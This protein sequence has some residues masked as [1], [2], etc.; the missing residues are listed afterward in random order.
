MLSAEWV[1][2]HG[3]L[4]TRREIQQILNARHPTF[5][6]RLNQKALISQIGGVSK[7]YELMVK[8]GSLSDEMLRNEVCRLNTELDFELD[9]AYYA[10]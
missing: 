5:V 4:N 10:R 6:P 7:W 9:R 3:I 1:R 2:I 8:Y